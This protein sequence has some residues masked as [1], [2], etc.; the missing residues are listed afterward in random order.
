MAAAVR[1]IAG[2]FSRLGAVDVFVPFTGPPIADGAFELTP[3]GGRPGGGWPESGAGAAGAARQRYR[4]AIVEAGDGAARWLAAT[5]APTSVLAIGRTP[6]DD[7]TTLLRV[8]L[9]G[10][11]GDGGGGDGERAGRVRAE[12]N[13][14][15]APPSRTHPV[16]LYARIDP[17]ASRRRHYGLR[18]VPDYLIVLGDRA[19]TPAPPWPS[20]RTRWLLARFA[21]RYVVVVEGGVARAW[22]SRSCV[23]EFEVHT[24]MD[25]WILMARATCVVDL[26][27]GEVYA[28]E[29]VEALRYGVP[30]AVPTGSAADGLV[31]HGGGV[32][33]SSTS[34]L[35]NC[36]ETLCDSASRTTFGERGR[37]LADHWYGDSGGLVARLSEVL[38]R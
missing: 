15:G 38:A 26:S 4:A 3:V 33:F 5:F 18:S 20:A 24:R 16:G 19:G 30:V 27:P 21:R 36:V 25:L 28:R 23:A 9:V 7:G 14:T 11:G 2:A 29:C 31:T 8:D 6:D 13:Q 35:C 17:A 22:R 12:A 37:A 1:S 34:E 32:G 10:G